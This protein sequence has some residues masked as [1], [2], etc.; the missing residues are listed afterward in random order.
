VSCCLGALFLGHQCLWNKRVNLPVDSRSQAEGLLA[1]RACFCCRRRQIAQGCRDW[2]KTMLPCHSLL[3]SIQDPYMVHLPRA[4][5]S[6]GT[7]AEACGTMTS[8]ASLLGKET[9]SNRLLS[10]TCSTHALSILCAGGE[11]WLPLCLMKQRSVTY[12]KTA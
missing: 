7:M 9:P 2:G 3:A 8:G 10:A 1:V 5:C 4:K 12:V 6:W 11:F